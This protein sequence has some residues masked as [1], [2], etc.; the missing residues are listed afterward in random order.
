MA[1]GGTEIYQG[2]SAGVKELKKADLTKHLNHLVLLTDGHTYGDETACLQLAESVSK[3]NISISAF[4]IGSEWNDEFLDKLVAPSGGRSNYIESPDEIVEHL[5]KH[6]HSLGVV[7]AHDV[8]LNLNLFPAGVKTAY[9]LKLKPY[10]QPVPIETNN[11]PLGVI[12]GNVT[13]LLLLELDIPPQSAGTILDLPLNFTANIP[14]EDSEE[15]RSVTFVSQLPVISGEADF[16]PNHVMVEAVRILSL[17]RM[18]E[19][20]ALEMEEGQIDKATQ[21]MRRLTTRLL[22][23]GFTKL[24]TQAH[25]ET[26]RLETMGTLSEDGRKKIKYGTRAM[27]TEAISLGE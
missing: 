12:E 14:T 15:S 26:Q 9:A 24:A 20:V 27:L 6:I 5:Q 4:G 3:Q 8:Q 23:S 16:T 7:Y 10:T 18:N 11:L 25:L 2:L 1:S 13:L 17:Y 22:Q 21:R 19:K